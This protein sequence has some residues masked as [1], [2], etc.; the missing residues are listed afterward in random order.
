[1][2]VAL[3]LL[4]QFMPAAWAGTLERSLPVSVS[5]LVN[6]SSSD[7]EIVA[8]KTTFSAI[9]DAASQRFSPL[10]IPFTVRS[11]SGQNVNYDLSMAQLAGQ[12]D[13]GALSLTLLAALDG[14]D[15]SLNEKRRAAGIKNS[16]VMEIKF[17][18][19]PQINAVQQCEGSLGIVAE[20]AV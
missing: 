7:L 8:D 18:Y 12:C 10:N 14:T 16:H 15:I 17:P 13:G 11:I 6:Q 1:M 19:L 5:I 20:L 9:Y 3:L 2:L 4:P